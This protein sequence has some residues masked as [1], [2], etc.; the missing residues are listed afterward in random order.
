MSAV[1]AGSG[2]L[3]SQTVS[4][5]HCTSASIVVVADLAYTT[6]RTRQA[7]GAAAD[8]SAYHT[9]VGAA[10]VVVAG[11]LLTGVGVVAAEA[12]WHGAVAGGAYTTTQVVPHFAHQAHGRT[13]AHDAP[14]YDGAF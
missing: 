14:L 8:G 4:G 13:I 2:R 9:F 3:A 10:E 11:A 12:A 7:Q 5:A 1:Q 6:V